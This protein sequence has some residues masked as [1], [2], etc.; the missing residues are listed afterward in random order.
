MPTA[1]LRPISMVLWVT[2]VAVAVVTATAGRPAPMRLWPGGTTP[3]A[4]S[5]MGRPATASHRG[6]QRP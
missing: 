2:L 5:A 3:S 4:R 1:N 6:G